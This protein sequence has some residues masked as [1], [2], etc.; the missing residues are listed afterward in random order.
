MNVKEAMK[1]LSPEQRD[2]VKQYITSIK[3][4]KKKITEVLAS[5][6][7]KEYGGNMSKNLILRNED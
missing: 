2:E 6:K 1:S 7:L 5:A 3:E 4:I